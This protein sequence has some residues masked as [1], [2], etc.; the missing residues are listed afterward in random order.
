MKTQLHGH[1]AKLLNSSAFHHIDLSGKTWTNS[2]GTDVYR[3]ALRLGKCVF[4]CA[5]KINVNS[6]C[7]PR[8]SKEKR[9]YRFVCIK[10]RNR[11]AGL[12]Y[13]ITG[14]NMVGLPNWHD[15]V[16]SNHATG[17]I[18]SSAVHKLLCQHQLLYKLFSI[19][20]T[21]SFLLKKTFPSC[22]H[23]ERPS[24]KKLLGWSHKLRTPFPSSIWKSGQIARPKWFYTTSPKAGVVET[25]Q[26]T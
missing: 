16:N 12:H 10:L 24:S 9:T 13:F 3:R 26:T 17:F 18:R 25:W 7:L 11:E 14:F 4:L 19:K 21:K 23:L 8:G 22:Q 5:Y 15:G 1:G 6:V 20:W 2:R